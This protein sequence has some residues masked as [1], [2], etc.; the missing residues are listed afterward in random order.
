LSSKLPFTSFPALFP[1]KENLLTIHLQINS[2]TT[3]LPLTPQQG[4]M[5]L[6]YIGLP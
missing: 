3:R 5:I 2:S 1:L 4:N 6:P